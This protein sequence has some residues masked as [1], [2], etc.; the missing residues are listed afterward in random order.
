MGNLPIAELCDITENKFCWGV[1][2][3]VITA[4]ITQPLC[5]TQLGGPHLSLALF[6]CLSDALSLSLSVSVSLSPAVC[7]TLS[8]PLFLS[9][10]L[11]FSH[12][13]FLSLSLPPP[14]FLSLSQDPAASLWLD[15]CI[16][17]HPVETIGSNPTCL[18]ICVKCIQ[19][20]PA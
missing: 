15:D 6:I 8:L 13:F 1:Q 2:S 5:L 9:T 17:S 18:H 3:K 12:L 10:S 4:I 20:D 19:R 16:H 11:S 7:R 14:L